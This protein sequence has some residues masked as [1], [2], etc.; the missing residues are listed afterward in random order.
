MMMMMMMI[1]HLW[2][3][4]LP[5]F[6]FVR[7]GRKAQ[8]HR[9]VAKLAAGTEQVNHELHYRSYFTVCNAWLYIRGGVVV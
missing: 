1:T 7:P 2:L 9:V 4:L 6:R 8:V 5:F 3:L